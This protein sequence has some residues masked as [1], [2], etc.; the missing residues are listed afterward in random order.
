VARIR[1]EQYP[2]IQ[3][4]IL[5][6]AAALFARVGYAS[7]SINDLA[8]A[9]ELSRGALYHYFPSKEAILLAIV[10]GHV[11]EFLSIVDAALTENR[12]AIDQF[13]AVTRAMIEC[14]ARSPNEQIVLLNDSNQLAKADRERV[15]S[16]GREIRDRLG[17]LLL[18]IDT[19]GK[20]TPANKRVYTMMYLGTINYAFAWYDPSGP[21]KPSEYGDLATDLFL[22]SLHTGA[23]YLKAPRARR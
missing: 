20:I 12:T 18:R 11:T 1:S 16:V 14:N 5:E 8:A 7:A 10:E 3:H 21:I 6:R 19:A 15:K 2:K 22:Q 13:R 9:A 4:F 17:D 23:A